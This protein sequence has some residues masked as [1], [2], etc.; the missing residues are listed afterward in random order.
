MSSIPQGDVCRL[1]GFLL[2]RTLDLSSPESLFHRES[3]CM[4]WRGRERPQEGVP[5]GGLVGPG[6]S[7]EEATPRLK[8][9]LCGGGHR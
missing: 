1:L 4:E 5:G 7:I 6:G 9:D 8:P 2:L 3:D